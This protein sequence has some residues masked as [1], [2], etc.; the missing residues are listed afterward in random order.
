MDYLVGLVYFLQITGTFLAGKV[1]FLVEGE[2]TAVALVVTE[3]RFELT[4]IAVGEC[5]AVKAAAGV[6]CSRTHRLH[7]GLYF[8]VDLDALLVERCFKFG[9]LFLLYHLV[10]AHAPEHCVRNKQSGIG[11]NL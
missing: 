4:E 3:R 5:H 9:H 1:D 6:G 2:F 7:L 10:N 8:L 11:G